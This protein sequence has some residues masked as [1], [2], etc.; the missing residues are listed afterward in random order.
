[1]SPPAREN[2]VAQHVQV[3]VGE[4]KRRRV[5]V[6]DEVDEHAG[7]VHGLLEMGEVAGVVEDLQAAAGYAPMGDRGV[8]DRDEWIPATPDDQ[9]GIICAR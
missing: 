9:R 1:M 8:L 7:E 6:L 4:L 5:G 2:A 3:L